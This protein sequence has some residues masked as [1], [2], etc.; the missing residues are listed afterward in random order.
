ML[1]PGI[2]DGQRPLI[3]GVNLF[4]EVVGKGTPLI[5]V[6]EFAGESQDMKAVLGRARVR[7]RPAILPNTRRR[8]SP[9]GS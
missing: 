4:Y 7:P 9:S 2:G 6:H 5:F 1:P 8:G 3:N